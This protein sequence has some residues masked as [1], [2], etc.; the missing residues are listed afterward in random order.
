MQGEVKRSERRRIAELGQRVGGDPPDLA[1][2]IVEGGR[3]L[4]DDVGGSARGQLVDGVGP[5]PRVGRGTQDG[6]ELDPFASPQGSARGGER[7]AGFRLPPRDLLPGGTRTT[8]RI[9]ARRSEIRRLRLPRATPLPRPRRRCAARHRASVVSPAGARRPLATRLPTGRRARGG[10]LPERAGPLPELV[11]LME[12]EDAEQEAGPEF[13]QEER[14]DE[15]PRPGSSRVARGGPPGHRRC[16][17]RRDRT[18]GR[19][20]QYPPSRAFEILKNTSVF[21]WRPTN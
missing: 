19:W 11:R 17:G 13:A 6:G 21:F 12:K 14:A 20:S 15:A 3:D 8:E 1:I 4:G 5:Q 2:W 9:G 10:P 16:P 7:R 18:L